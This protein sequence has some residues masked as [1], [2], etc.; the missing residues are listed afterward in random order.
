MPMKHQKG[1]RRL[2]LLL[3]IAGAICA[4]FASFVEFL[5]SLKQAARHYG[6]E[7]L[8][9]SQAVQDSRNCWKGLLTERGCNEEKRGPGGVKHQ[10]GAMEAPMA[11]SLVFPN[12]QAVPLRDGLIRDFPISMN[13]E[14]I[15]DV[16]EKE[17]PSGKA[18]VRHQQ[19]T[20]G[21][22]EEFPLSVIDRGEISVVRWNADLRIASIETREGQN[23]YPTPL[24]PWWTYPLIVLFPILGFLIPW[25]TVRAFRPD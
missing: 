7:N 18:V 1:I 25:G 15:E 5:P 11:W 12:S 19:I 13:H 14:Q 2:A 21:P 10:L 6:F 20:E 3:G 17:F 22:W 4:A 24:P 9:N 8:A 23:L 16:L